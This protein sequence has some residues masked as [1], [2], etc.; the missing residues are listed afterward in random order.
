MATPKP[1]VKVPKTASQGEVITIKTLISHPMESGQRKDK[2]GNAIPRQII[3]KFTCEFNGQVVFSCDMD[4]AVSA[5]PYME[6]TAK[7]NEPGTFKFTWVDDDGS[8]FETEN[9]IVIE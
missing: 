1:R 9:K 4:P 8:V 6:F 7:I 3:N 2:D 5:N